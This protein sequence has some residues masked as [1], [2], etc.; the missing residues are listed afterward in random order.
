MAKGLWDIWEDWKI[1]IAAINEEEAARAGKEPFPLLDFS[2][3][4]RFTT[5]TIPN[6]AGVENE[7]QFFWDPGHYRQLLGQYVFDAALG[8]PPV[9]DP[10]FG[11]VV[12]STN[13]PAHLEAIRR[14]RQRYREGN[15]EEVSELDAALAEMIAQKK[16]SQIELARN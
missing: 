3:Y 10:D 12:N 15:A 6:L 14:A 5:E 16:L 7:L 1:M 11:V 8:G 4:N 2:G 9:G 13:M